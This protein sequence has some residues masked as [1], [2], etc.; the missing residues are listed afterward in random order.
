MAIET[1][2]SHLT[3][4]RK[5]RSIADMYEAQTLE[6]QQMLP[7]KLQKQDLANER[8]RITNESLR[9]LYS[10]MLKDEDLNN[11]IRRNKI[12]TEEAMAGYYKEK[13]PEGLVADIT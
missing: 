7:G 3:G 6:T 8:S 11:I 5:Q 2:A 9:H 10:E 12:R 13:G 1:V 4:Q